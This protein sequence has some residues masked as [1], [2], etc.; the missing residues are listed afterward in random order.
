MYLCFTELGVGLQLVE[1]LNCGIQQA[2][3]SNCGPFGTDCREIPSSFYA[4]NSL[5]LF[6]AFAF[7]RSTECF[8]SKVT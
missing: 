1:L 7:H 3:V 8:K 6:R 2:D 5:N 4:S